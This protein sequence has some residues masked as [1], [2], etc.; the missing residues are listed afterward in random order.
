MVRE[1]VGHEQALV[2]SKRAMGDLHI[3]RGH[4]L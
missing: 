4:L 2:S 1:Y 3:D